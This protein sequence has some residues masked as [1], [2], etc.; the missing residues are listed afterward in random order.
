MHMGESNVAAPKVDEVIVREGQC[1]GV[2]GECIIE[3]NS[4]VAKICCGSIGDGVIG[5]QEEELRGCIDR[6]VVKCV[7]VVGVEGP[8]ARPVK[9]EGDRGAKVREV[10]T[11][12]G[13]SGCGGGGS[14]GGQ[15]GGVVV[16]LMK[17]LCMA[18]IHM[19]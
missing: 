5:E 9:G 3:G 16:G 19:M 12:H 11:H 1:T 4:K 7:V 15:G 10:G 14:G 17:G 2:A 6:L 18:R 13:W 8:K